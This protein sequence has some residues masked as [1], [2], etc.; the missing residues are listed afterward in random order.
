MADPGRGI[1][2]AE[3]DSPLGHERLSRIAAGLADQFALLYGAKPA[4]PR[5][6]MAG[7][8]LAFS[9]QGG[10]SVA[11]EQHLRAER[12]DA[13]RS[14][15][16]RFLEVVADRLMEVAASLSGGRVTFFSS[17]FDPVGRL[18]PRTNQI[19]DSNHEEQ[20]P[21]RGV[22]AHQGIYEACTT[23]KLVKVHSSTP[24]RPGSS[25]DSRS[26]AWSLS[27][28]QLIAEAIETNHVGVR[29][30]RTLDRYRDNLVQLQPLPQQRLR[31]D[32]LLSEAQARPHVH[33]P[34]VEAGWPEAA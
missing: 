27:D 15:R 9:F 19:S 5:A 6:Q 21:F 13:V 26:Y 16:E 23:R 18:Q 30:D 10:L 22:R 4:D 12:A 31:R 2:T 29:K 20:G 28:Q 25:T 7:N 33:E 14:F 3:A 34:P 32:L 17:A 8:M 24:P 1:G 11:D